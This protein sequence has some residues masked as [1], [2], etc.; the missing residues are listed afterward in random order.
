MK[1]LAIT[2]SDLT[3]KSIVC[4]ISSSVSSM[5]PIMKKP[6]Q[7]IPAREILVMFSCALI[8]L[9]FFLMAFCTRELPD[10][11]ATVIQ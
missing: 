7:L 1:K 4:R 6:L 9:T 3:A 2:R 11:M 8:R 10:S 5:K